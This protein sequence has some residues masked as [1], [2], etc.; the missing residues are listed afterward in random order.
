MLENTNN[1]LSLVEFINHYVKY[2]INPDKW[3]LTL[4]INCNY[5]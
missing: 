4:K 3:N 2:M 1:P 5:V